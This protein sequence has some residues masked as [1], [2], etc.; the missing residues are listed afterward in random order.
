ML[1]LSRLACAAVDWISD[2]RAAYP[3]LQLSNLCLEAGESEKRIRE[4]FG[5]EWQ[6]AAELTARLLVAWRGPGAQW[7]WVRSIPTSARPS[8]KGLGTDREP[9]KAAGIRLLARAAGGPDRCLIVSS[10]IYTRGTCDDRSCE[11]AREDRIAGFE[12][13]CG[14][15]IA[16]TM[17]EHIAC[18]IEQNDALR[19]RVKDDG[20][21]RGYPGISERLFSDVVIADAMP[22][23]PSRTRSTWHGDVGYPGDNAET[24]ELLLAKGKRGVALCS[25][26]TVALAEAESEDWEPLEV[27]KGSFANEHALDLRPRGTR[28]WRVSDMIIH[29]E[30]GQSSV[31]N[32][33]WRPYGMPDD[34]ASAA[35]IIALA[36]EAWPRE[37]MERARAESSWGSISASTIWSHA[38]LRA[39]LHAADSAVLS[40]ERRRR[41]T[42][43]LRDEGIEPDEDTLL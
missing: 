15:Q 9:G 28:F 13:E 23:G 7:E 21:E 32:S 35:A 30:I 1:T 31:R 14:M 2:G 12:A 27:E 10:L 33:C 42:D 38:A 6:Q 20:L 26:A 19:R 4:Y 25:P 41:A 3:G 11:R 24:L 29:E 37:C 40:A 39:V 17:A 8:H 5:A 43:L 34:P 18:Q 36:E 16:G 22:C